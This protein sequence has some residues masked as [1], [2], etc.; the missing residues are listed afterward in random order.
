[1][2]DYF[3]DTGYWIALI[4]PDDT[5]HQ[6]ATEYNTLL[7]MEGARIVT[8]ELVL[9]ELLNPRSGTTRRRRQTAIDLVDQIRMNPMVTI[10]PQSSEQFNEA[11]E[12]LRRRVDQ[13]WSITDCA[14]FLV[15]ERYGITAALTGDHHFTQAGFFVLLR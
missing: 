7:E 3:G 10:E 13:E 9:N 1:M 11:L 14:S 8:T 12:R 2:S 5:L 15:M 6:Q 4:D